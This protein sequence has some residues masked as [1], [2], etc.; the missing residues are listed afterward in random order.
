[1]H[2]VF[3]ILFVAVLILLLCLPAQAVTIQDLLERIEG[4]ELRVE[5][6]EE[7]VEKLQSQKQV[8]RQYGGIIAFFKGEW[9]QNTKPFV[10]KK[11][12]KIEWQ[13][14]A[15]IFN[16]AIHTKERNLVGIVGNT[17]RGVSY[18]LK[19]GTYYLSVISDDLWVIIVKE[20]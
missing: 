8:T 11:P 4:L 3:F 16:V 2:R 15:N 18:Q 9:T 14:R 20:E 13:T 19:P 10:A 5:E 1:M 7:T 6:L 17:Q 12:W